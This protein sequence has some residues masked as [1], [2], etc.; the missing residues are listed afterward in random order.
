MKRDLAVRESHGMNVLCKR[1]GGV[2]TQKIRKPGGEEP[3][4]R[5]M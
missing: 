4:M 1:A 2:R 5:V 3:W